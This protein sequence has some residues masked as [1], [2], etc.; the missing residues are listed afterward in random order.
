MTR[1]AAFVSCV[2]IT[3]VSTVAWL[4]IRATSAGRSIALALGAMLILV[5]IPSWHDSLAASRAAATLAAIPA[6][7]RFR[8][9]T[10][11]ARS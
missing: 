6:S 11:S 10:A 4:A 2:Y 1:I 7:W 9:S 5:A 8:R 3:L